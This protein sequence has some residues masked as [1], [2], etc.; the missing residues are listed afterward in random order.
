MIHE[1]RVMHFSGR[2]QG[3]GFRWRT[4]RALE[5]S[6]LTGFVQNLPDGRVKLV[7]EGAPAHLDAA[8]AVIRKCLGPYIA[9]EE[10]EIAPATGEFDEFGVRR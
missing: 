4:L 7:V 5:G 3:V 9:R 10:V 6:G 2:V 1:R 8:V